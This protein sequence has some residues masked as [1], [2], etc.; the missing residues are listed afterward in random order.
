[1]NSP[2]VPIIL[3]NIRYFETDGGDSWFGGGIDLTPHYVDRDEAVAF[4][5]AL[6][7]T[8]D[9]FDP[10]YYTKFKDIAD[11]Y[12]YIAHRDETRGIGGI[13][14]DHLK[15]GE[16]KSFDELFDF[17]CAVGRTFA[18]TYVGL[19]NKK[20][21]QSFTE[22]EKTWQLIRRGRYVEFNLVYDRGTKFGLQTN[23]RAESI[24]MSL[25]KLASWE[26]NHKPMEGSRESETLALLKKG[27]KWVDQ[28]AV[29]TGR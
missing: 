28:P 16:S 5:S 20:K 14:F 24:L 22:A 7:S 9:K 6:K 29:Q 27:V 19:V 10:A 8:C 15:P 25:P 23:W 21:G 3:M 4:H 18:P 11:D 26:Y 17:V 13:F 12:F 2:H 1:P